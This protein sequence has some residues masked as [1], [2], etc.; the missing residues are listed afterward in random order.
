MNA[1]HLSNYVLSRSES[2]D[3]CSLCPSTESNT[4]A[5]G[6]ALLIAWGPS[7]IATYLDRLLRTEVC[8]ARL[9]HVA[10]CICQVQPNLQPM[11]VESGPTHV[12]CNRMSNEP[13]MT[14]SLPN[15]KHYIFVGKTKECNT[16]HETNCGQVED[17]SGTPDLCHIPQPRNGLSRQ[18]HTGRSAQNHC[19]TTEKLPNSLCNGHRMMHAVSNC[20]RHGV[21]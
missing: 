21:T 20:G 7:L 19:N 15:R 13:F 4:Q 12:Q 6:G 9:T 16:C 1:G 5:P 3:L 8:I 10:E 17:Q 2:R 18:K 14:Q 11:Q